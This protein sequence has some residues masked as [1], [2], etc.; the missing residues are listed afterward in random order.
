MTHPIFTFSFAFISYKKYP[1][2]LC[3]FLKSKA[4]IKRNTS[5]ASIKRNVVL[6]F[7]PET[8]YTAKAALLCQDCPM[9]TA[10]SQV[11]VSKLFRMRL[12]PILGYL[13]DDPNIIGGGS[14]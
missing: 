5:T 3:Y 11:G 1:L 13:N 14:P 9:K 6:Y 2:L 7:T 4:S 10:Q 12:H 8:K